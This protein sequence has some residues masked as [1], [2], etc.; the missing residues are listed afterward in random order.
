MYEKELASMVSAVKEASEEIMRIY[1]AGFN[2]KM[3][4][5]N[6]PVTDAD[7]ASN[8]IIRKHL[9]EFKDISWLSEEDADNLERL[10]AKRIWVIDPLDGTQ[11]FV[12]HDDSFAINIALV[13]DNHPVVAVIGQPF[14]S[15]YAYA[16]KGQGAYFVDENGKETKMHVSSRTKDL[17]ILTSKTHERPEELAIY[18][19]Y[20]SIIK[21]VSHLGAS[22]KAVNIGLGLADCSIRYTTGT[23]EWDVCAP[24]L[25]MTESGGLL[26][27]TKLNTFT[28]NRADVH[29]H[30]GYCMFNLKE[31]ERLLK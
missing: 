12:N 10:K 23:K 24:D 8:K 6:S 14:T 5:D 1:K 9:S 31:N 2:I 30:F 17:I 16:V 28:Y 18:K 19:K 7:L 21:E 27:D 29:N 22:N 26:V 25:I 15:S 20:A 11:D 4:E 13:E 3:K